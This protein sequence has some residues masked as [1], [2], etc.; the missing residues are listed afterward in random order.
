MAN[1]GTTKNKT[2]IRS[3]SNYQGVDTRSSFSTFSK[4]L[5]YRSREDKTIIDSAWMIPGSQNVLIDI[6]GRLKNRL[7]YAID[8]AK[9]STITPIYGFYDWEE[10]KNGIINFRTYS[11][12]LQFRYEYPAGVFTWTTIKDSLGLNRVRFT[13]YW[14][15]TEKE[16]CVLFVDGSTNVYKW[17]GATTTFD[18]A[19][20]T[21][22][23]V[24]AGDALNQTSLWILNGVTPTF[25]NS[26]VLYWGLTDTAGT[27]TINIYRASDGAPGNL[28]ASG[29]YVGNG[30]I[31]L[32]EQNSSGISGSVE[33]TYTADDITY[34][35]NTLTL[36]YTITKQGT[37][38]WAESDFYVSGNKKITIRGVEYTYTGGEATTTL[39]GVT[40]DPS[41]QGAN[42]PVA[43]DLV[44]QSVVTSTS[45]TAVESGFKYDGISNSD[46]QIYYGSLTNNN[47]YVSKQNDYTTCAFTAPLRVVGEGALMTLRAPF[48]GFEPQEAGMYITAGKSQ[49]YET[50]RILD[51]TGAKEV[52]DI[53]PLKTSAKQAAISQEAITHDRNSVVMLTNE[54]KLVT[55]GRTLNIFGTPMMTDYSY[56]ITAD[57]NTFN[58][59][60]AAIKYWKSYIL[61]A[62]PK[63]S[64]WYILNQTDPNNMFWEAPQTGAFSGFMEDGDGNVYAHSYS[65]PE[66]YKLFSGASDDGHAIRSVA[67]F[68]YASYGN[69]GLSDYFNEYW[70]EGYI[71]ANTELTITYNLDLDGCA[72]TMSGVLHGNDTNVVCA[73]SGTP[74]L[75][76]SSLGKAPL[77]NHGL[78]TDSLV[79]PVTMPPFFNAV[80]ISPR[81]DFYKFSPKFE[82]TGIG[83][84]WQLITMGPLVTN[85]LF[86][87][88]SIKINLS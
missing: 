81:K 83:Y 40:P 54:T 8:G 68:A 51:S 60:D 12:N 80:L 16:N 18:S 78:G 74:E 38:T 9:N 65:T 72:T 36:S 42:I 4:F 26:F 50:S 66:T 17:N 53:K 33:V 32:T 24:E 59:T 35:A 87:N 30:N 25:S 55:L 85:T 75:A 56:P 57:F 37:D 71:S 77:G 39:T 64:K 19:S 1:T 44:Y 79:N 67:Q 73:L 47:I 84:D 86:G 2:K 20:A 29:S 13:N 48:V 49:W 46:N 82:S 28:V 61:I 27:R 31:T 45:I 15:N 69:R 63:E 10:H 43:N 14:D 11:G 76:N 5:G 6:T 34:S 7:G 62:I 52:F 58:F 3:A 41:A 23:I 21:A 22:T 70:M 88:N